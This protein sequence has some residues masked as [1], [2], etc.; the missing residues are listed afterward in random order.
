MNDE[1]FSD[2]F[3]NAF[4][5]D[6]LAPEEKSRVYPIIHDDPELSRRVCEVRKIR[7]LIQLAYKEPP[8]A[9]VRRTP[10]RR[11]WQG[12]HVAAVLFLG[13][14]GSLGWALHYVSFGASEPGS[15]ATLPSSPATS[16]SMT[17]AKPDSA[18]RLAAE[19]PRRFEVPPRR[20]GEARIVLH[21]S[22][23][24][25]QHMREVLDEAEN[26]LQYYAR[27]SQPARIELITNGEG[28]NLLRADTSPFAAR[29]SALQ[30]KYSNL[31]FAACQNTIDR[32]EREQGIQ[33]QLLP[34]A[35]VIDS[36]VAQ[37][38]LL[39]QQGWAYIQV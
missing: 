15:G 39:Q 17:A 8:A 25:M 11:R 19:G 22:R 5:D 31:T 14:G 26:L 4:A 6:Q 35:V 12:L 38:I 9:P 28:L 18:T 29:I 33:A 36:G 7:D 30:R 3:I 34:E 37:I 23:G 20:D 27:A 1:R 10:A 24:N 2:E 13:V 21:L 32:L 16:A